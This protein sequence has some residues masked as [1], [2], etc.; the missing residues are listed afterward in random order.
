VSGEGDLI[1]PE[2]VQRVFKGTTLSGL[3]GVKTRDTVKREFL[4]GRSTTRRRC[5]T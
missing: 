3:D 1:F 4:F 5:G 2:I